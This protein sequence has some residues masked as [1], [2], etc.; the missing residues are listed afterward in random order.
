MMI[1]MRCLGCKDL[2]K[3][4][5]INTFLTGC[6]YD[7]GEYPR[8]ANL[9]IRDAASVKVKRAFLARIQEEYKL[10]C[11]NYDEALLLKDK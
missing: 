9:W 3:M 8:A 5:H 11:A 1:K 2:C 10:D 7:D 4:D 6:V